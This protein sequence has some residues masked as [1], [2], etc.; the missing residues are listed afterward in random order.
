MEE[1]RQFVVERLRKIPGIATI[2]SFMGLDLYE[3]KFE[4]GV[5]G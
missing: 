2:E 1:Y 4:L 5:I 3:R